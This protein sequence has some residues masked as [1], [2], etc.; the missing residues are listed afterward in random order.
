MFEYRGSSENFKATI[1]EF[2]P[3][4]EKLYKSLLGSDLQKVGYF[5]TPG[6]YFT[7]GDMP[8]VASPSPIMEVTMNAM[9]RVNSGFYM[10]ML[11]LVELDETLTREM[12]RRVLKGLGYPYARSWIEQGEDGGRETEANDRMRQYFSGLSNADFAALVGNWD[13]RTKADAITGNLLRTLRQYRIQ[14]KRTDEF[15]GAGHLFG[16]NTVAVGVENDNLSGTAIMAP[17]Y[18]QIRI[19]DDG[20]IMLLDT[21]RI[22]AAPAIKLSDEGVAAIEKDLIG[23]GIPQHLVSF[24]HEFDHFIGFCLASYPLSVVRALL[25]MKAME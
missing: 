4:L 23:T 7:P 13:R 15:G 17:D 18:R 11:R 25:Y 8:E 14:K 22:V 21:S 10:R 19:A 2:G 9:E 16:F 6:L 5:D 1:E 20:E 24:V 3:R 12:D